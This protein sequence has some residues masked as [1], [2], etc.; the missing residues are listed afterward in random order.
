MVIG[1]SVR[2]EARTR[3]RGRCLYSVL[4]LISAEVRNAGE[5]KRG[6]GRRLLVAC[7]S[8]SL[9]REEGSSCDQAGYIYVLYDLQIPR[10]CGVD[11]LIVCHGRML[12]SGISTRGITPNTVE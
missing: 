12:E 8:S 4:E 1:A 10:W 7:Q 6:M 2:S 3:P 5:Q 11:Q 9:K